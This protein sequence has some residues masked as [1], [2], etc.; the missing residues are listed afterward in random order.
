MN[1]FRKKFRAFFRYLYLSLLHM[2]KKA[3]NSPMWREMYG[4]TLI[5]SPD[6]VLAVRGQKNG[7]GGRGEGGGGRGEGGGGRGEG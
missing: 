3:G 5:S 2:R 7:G 6:L 1:I 4:G